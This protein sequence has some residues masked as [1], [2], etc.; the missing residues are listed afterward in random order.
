M[1]IASTLYGPSMHKLSVQHSSATARGRWSKFDL[2]RRQRFVFHLGEQQHKTFLVE[3]FFF[4]FLMRRVDKSQISQTTTTTHKRQHPPYF[5]HF[6][7]LLFH[8]KKNLSPLHYSSRFPITTTRHCIMVS[9]GTNCH[10]S[11]M[12]SIIPRHGGAC[13]E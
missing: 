9:T 5:D 1:I 10:N 6:P 4:F 12:G 3:N 7:P 8:E 11:K 2:K 13:G